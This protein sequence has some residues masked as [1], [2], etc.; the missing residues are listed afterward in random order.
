MLVRSPYPIICIL[1]RKEFRHVRRLNVQNN[2]IFT[3]KNGFT[4]TCEV[5][6]LYGLLTL[7]VTLN[8]H[9]LRTQFW[10]NLFMLSYLQ[11]NMFQA[12]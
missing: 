6:K 4:A 1:Y 5:R 8:C 12:S 7:T 9:V 10:Q 2:K 3:L 11:V